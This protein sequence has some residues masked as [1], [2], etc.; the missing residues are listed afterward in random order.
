MFIRCNYFLCINISSVHQVWWLKNGYH[1]GNNPK[2]AWRYHLH[3]LEISKTS[4]EPMWINGF[5]KTEHSIVQ[6]LIA[7]A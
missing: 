5:A 7:L 6:V 1:P 4:N 2:Y 3:K